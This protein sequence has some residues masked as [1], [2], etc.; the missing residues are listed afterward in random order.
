MTSQFDSPHPLNRCMVIADNLELLEAMDNETVDLI[1]TDPPFAKNYAFTGRLKPPLSTKELAL[2]K[3]TLADWEIHDRAAAGKSNIEWPDN[4]DATARF[5]DIWTWEKDIHEEWLDKIEAQHLAVAKVIDAARYS[6]SDGHAAYL[7]YMAIRIIQMHRVLKPTGLMYLHCD[8][9]ANSYLRLVMDAVFGQI[10]LRNEMTWTYG[11]MSNAIKNFASNHDTILR[12]SKSDDYTHNP[13]KKAE[14]EYRNRYKRFLSNN[15]VLY[16]SVKNSNDKLILGRV[17]KVTKELGRELV[18]TDILF[19][20]DKEFKKQDDVIYLSHI[21]GN[22]P[23]KTGYPTQKP[24]RLAEIF[25]LSSSNP[26]DV[27]LDPFAGCAYVPV[28]AERMGRQWIACDINPR[29]LT[30]VRRQFSKFHYA[31]DGQN[32]NLAMKEEGSQTALI[33]DADIRIIRPGDIPERTTRDPISTVTIKRRERQFKQPSS[34]IPKA[35]MR[36]FLLKLSDWRCWTCGFANTFEASPGV[37]K[38]DRSADNFVL[39]HVIPVSQG[40]DHQITNRAALCPSC[41]NRK[42][43]RDITLTAFRDENSQEGRLRVASIGLLVDLARARHKALEY[44]VEYR[45]KRLQ[46]N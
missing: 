2:E 11:K 12:Y 1:V 16:G 41:N 23:E 27:V 10:N 32:P 13:V 8:P 29:A 45:N 25:I 24:V 14:S 4:G 33:A 28:A 3:Q 21:K 39:D 35:E 30:V 6:H 19:N 40:G 5:S 46:S 31:V 36:N 20:F 43:G 18:D 22:H 15:K 7:S 9:T 42:S 38:L 44:Y 34:D 17:K 26:G 37:Y